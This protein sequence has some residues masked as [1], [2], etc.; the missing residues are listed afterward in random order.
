M[1]ILGATK[2]EI[3]EAAHIIGPSGRRVFAAC[4]HGHKLF[5]DKFFFELCPTAR[6]ITAMARYNGKKDYAAKYRKTYYRNIGSILYPLEYGR[7]C[8]C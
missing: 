7:A 2:A 4:W 5:F 8:L 3:V 6:V 1:K